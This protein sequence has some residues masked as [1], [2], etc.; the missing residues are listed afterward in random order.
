[1]FII[2]ICLLLIVYYFRK[3]AL[4]EKT[5]NKVVDKRTHTFLNICYVFNCFQKYLM[6]FQQRSSVKDNLSRFSGLFLTS[7]HQQI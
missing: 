2:V 6:I 3:N 1:M 7:T 4:C 5:E